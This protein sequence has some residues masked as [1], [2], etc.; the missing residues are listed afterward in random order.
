MNTTTTQNLLQFQKC[1]LSFPKHIIRYFF[2]KDFLTC[3]FCFK[4]H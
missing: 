1:T 2:Q 4:V 3:V